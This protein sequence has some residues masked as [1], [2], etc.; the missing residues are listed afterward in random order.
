MLK[1]RVVL[2]TPEME[3]KNGVTRIIYPSGSTYEGEVRDGKRHGLGVYTWKQ[4]DSYSGMWFMGLM[5]GLGV[6]EYASEAAYL[7]EWYLGDRVGNGMYFYCPSDDEPH[8]EYAGAWRN[9][10]LHGIGKRLSKSGTVYLG[11]FKAGMRHGEGICR[12]AKDSLLDPLGAAANALR[13][14]SNKGATGRYSKMDAKAKSEVDTEAIMGGIKDWHYEDSGVIVQEG[15]FMSDE[16]EPRD[17]AEIQMKKM[18]EK[19]EAI[20]A[21]Q[22][23]KERE[24]AKNDVKKQKKLEEEEQKEKDE[25]EDEEEE[26][27]RE[28]PDKAEKRKQRQARL[29]AMAKRQGKVLASRDFPEDRVSVEVY[30]PLVQIAMETA[31]AAELIGKKVISKYR[32]VNFHFRVSKIE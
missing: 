20:K 27:M 16:Y 9:D 25:E 32:N 15:R 13:K 24:K 17:K 31:D 2:G 30:E 26:E 4:G 6:A 22:R 5:H 14:F 28:D 1:R 11:N 10:M 19:K 7:G 18:K 12:V 3:V 8:K 23:E 29:R 21:E